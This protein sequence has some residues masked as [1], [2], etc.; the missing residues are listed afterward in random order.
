MDPLLT[1]ATTDTTSPAVA[2]T[3]PV[4]V[5]VSGDSV[6][7]GAALIVECWPEN[8]PAKFAPTG[9][10]IDKPGAVTVHG[11]GSYFIRTK[12]ASTSAK[13]NVTAVANQ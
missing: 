10:I 1:N 3:G 6:F 11:Q 5:I 7:A 4:N 9:I 2:C 8:T 13:T 12:L